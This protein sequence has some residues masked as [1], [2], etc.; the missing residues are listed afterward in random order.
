MSDQIPV[1]LCTVFI[2]F[3]SDQCV[4]SLIFSLAISNKLQIKQ[5][6]NLTYDQNI[7]TVGQLLLLMF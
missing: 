5:L 3:Y 2:I 1:S 7:T 6:R 4:L